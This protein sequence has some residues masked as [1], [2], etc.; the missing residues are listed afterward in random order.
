MEQYTEP[1]LRW[2]GEHPKIVFTVIVGLILIALASIVVGFDLIGYAV[3][4]W[5]ALRQ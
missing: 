1:V 2:F 3:R 4:W 5:D